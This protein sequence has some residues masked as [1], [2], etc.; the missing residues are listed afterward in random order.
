MRR[1]RAGA[2]AP[3]S[4]LRSALVLAVPEAAPAVDAWRERTSAAK[5]SNGVP[6]P[7]HDPLSVHPGRRDRRRASRG[8]ASRVRPVP[9]VPLRASR[10][11]ALP[12]SPLPR[13]GA[14]GAVRGLDRSGRRRI[15]GVRA[16]RRGVRLDRSAP[17]R[18]G[19]G[20]GAAE[21]GRARDPAALCRFR[22]RPTRWC[23]SRRCEPDLARWRTRARIPLGR[24]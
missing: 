16:V 15:S 13:P 11:P 23:F 8:R 12:R 2:R 9:R 19:R 20:S 4:G 21:R 17:H 6:R 14:P 1:G 24:P 3:V 7:R 18:G 10:D 22:P 5:P